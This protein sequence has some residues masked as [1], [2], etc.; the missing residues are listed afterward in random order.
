M[1]RRTR[2]RSATGI[3]FIYKRLGGQFEIMVHR[4]NWRS[5]V[6][7]Y[8]GCPSLTGLLTVDLITCL[9]PAA[10]SD[11]TL[12]IGTSFLKFPL[13]DIDECWWEARLVL[14]AGYSDPRVPEL[15]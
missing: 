10:F 5:Q 3:E 13:D 12:L 15:R 1:R 9:L 8:S 11:G 2:S 14:N 6:L 4:R 7:R